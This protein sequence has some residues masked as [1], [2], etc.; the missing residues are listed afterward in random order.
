MA[1]GNQPP[2]FA[3]YPSELNNNNFLDYSKEADRKLFKAAIKGMDTK[4]ELQASDLQVFLS[5]VAM[6]AQIYNF[7]DVLTING[8]N[9]IDSYG[10]IAMAE[11][12]TQAE[13]YVAQQ[14]RNAQNSVML[15]H[16]LVDSLSEAAKSEVMATPEIYTVTVAN[17]A[18]TCVGATFLKTIIQKAY[19]DTKATVTSIR[20]ALARLDHKMEELNGDVKAFNDYVTGLRN[21]LRA[22]GESTD[23]IISH[24]FVG[25]AAASDRDFVAYMSQKRNEYEDGESNMDLNQIMQRALNKYNILIQSGR[26]NEPDKKDAAIFALKA[27]VESLEKANKA[28]KPEGATAGSSGGNG[29]NRRA[30]RDKKWAWK[31]VKPS[32]G[33]SLSKEFQGKTYYWCPKH[34]AWTAHKPEDCKGKDFF[35][36]RDDKNSDAQSDGKRDG[37]KL[38]LAMQALIDEEDEPSSNE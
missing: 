27:K 10:D 11:I 1:D 16:F 26:W 34:E 3:L 13:T 24:I 18:Y 6:H 20:H 5:K 17:T 8:K 35:R 31:N 38:K 9:L 14:N 19:V 25:Y 30:R 4:F 22:R 21:M 37:N 12:T 33:E 7:N 15:Y 28:I 32:Q 23:D 29:N 36:K 2:V